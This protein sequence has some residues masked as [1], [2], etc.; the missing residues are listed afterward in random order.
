MRPQ[1]KI[2]LLF[3]A[4]VLIWGMGWPMNKLGMQ[5]IPGLWFAAFRLTIA[6][7]LVFM[8]AGLI[9]KWIWPNK[10]DLPIIL[11]MGFLQMGFYTL[12]I[13][14]GLQFVEAGRSSILT[15]TASFWVIPLAI[16]FFNEKINTLKWLGFILGIAGILVLFSPWTID[17]SDKQM[18]LGNSLL[19][20]AALSFALS[21]I[22]ARNM[23]WHRSSL[24]LLPW[25][26]LVGAVFV[27]LLAC[28]LEPHPT[29][30]WNSISYGTLFYTGV[31]GT[32]FGYPGVVII[33]KSLPSITVS[34]GFLGV[35]VCGLLF[36]MLILD[37]PI[38]KAII[39]AMILIPA[40]LIC[41]AMSNRKVK[42]A[43]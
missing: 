5:Y 24:E 28:Y 23:N 9:G 29:L 2:Y 3:A 34:L 30:E 37:E 31:L 22:C 40:G 4:V 11:S 12:F 38:T 32:A 20:L 19:L 14:L 25:Q 27:T 36:S 6:A 17:W 18:L 1:T 39:I 42:R 26:L 8:G 13:N 35:P 15:N 7:I 33:S 10:R 41:V 21:I 16:I 43:T